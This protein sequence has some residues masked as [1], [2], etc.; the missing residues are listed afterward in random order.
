MCLGDKVVWH[1]YGLGERLDHHHF[2]FDGNNFHSDG[3]RIDT[4]SVFPGTSKTV[5][6]IP[7]QAGELRGIDILS[8]ETPLSKP[9]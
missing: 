1:M 3:R 7:D 9:V 5:I 2:G 4:A 6:M 8:K